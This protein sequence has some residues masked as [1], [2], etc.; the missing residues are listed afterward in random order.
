LLKFLSPGHD[1]GSLYSVFLGVEVMS[2][3]KIVSEGT[4]RCLMS[5]VAALRE[6]I[7][8]VERNRTISIF[9]LDRLLKSRRPGFKVAKDAACDP[10]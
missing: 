7:D 3:E 8:Q 6:Q 10:A 4:L 5:E 2:V 9:A 1:T